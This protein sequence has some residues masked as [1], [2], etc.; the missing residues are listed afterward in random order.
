[1]REEWRP[2]VGY[3]GYYMVS[4]LGNVKSLNY[5]GTGKEKILKPQKTGDSY[6]QV[7]LYLDGKGKFYLVH[8]LVAQAF[9]PN[10][11][12]LPEVNHKDENPKNNN[13]DNLEWC[14]SKY[15][16]NYGTRNQ[17][18]AEKISK[19]VLAIDKRT[20]L[21]LKFVSSI[22]AERETGIDQSNIIK[23][24][25]GKRNSCGCFYWMYAD[26]DADAE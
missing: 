11:D 22:E 18:V 1:M 5:R 25:K 15:N 17:R 2:L 12:N 14:T 24:C 7:H 10:P 20:G 6:L 8:R 9:L 16:S 23:C 13:V 19:P 3:E 26:A 4:N 21:I